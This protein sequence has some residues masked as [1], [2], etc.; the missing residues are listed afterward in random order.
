MKTYLRYLAK[1]SIL[2][3]LLLS[4]TLIKCGSTVELPAGDPDNGGLFLPDGFE[5]IVVVDSLKGRARHMAVNDNGDIYVKARFPREGGNIALRD[6]TGD[7]K[8]DIIQQFGTYKAD[9]TYGTAMRIHNGYLYYSSQLV[10]YRSKLKPGQLLPDTTHEVILTDDHAHGS[11]EHVA[12]PITFD[13]RGNMYVPFGANSNNCQEVNRTPN[14]PGMNPCPLLADHGGIWRFDAS[15]PGQLQKDGHLFAT[16]LR[17]VVALDWN[18]QDKNLYA[19]QHGRDDLLRLWSRFFSPWESA[20]LPSEEFLRVKDGTHAGWP[21]CYYDQLKGQKLLAPEYGGDGTMAGDCGKY[22]KPLIGFPGH[23][24]PNDLLFYQGNQFPERYR[25]G[26]F[27]AFHGS[28]N[29]GPYPQAGYFIAFVPFKDGQPSGPWEVFADGFAGVDPI[30]NTRDAKYRPMG[31]AMGP[32]GS[33]YFSDTEKGKIWR[34]MYKGD[35]DNFGDAQLAKMEERKSLSNIRKP[36]EINDNLDKGIAVGGEKVYSVY[37]GTCHQRDG[38]G[39]SGRFPPLAGASFVKGDKKLLISI[40]IKGMEGPIEVNG[41]QFNATM[42]QHSFLSNEDIAKVLTYI[43]ENFGNNASA[44][45]S[46]E[47]EAVRKALD[48]N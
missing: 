21:Y 9:G 30:V 25:N 13:D 44:V 8:A 3:F 27:I 6:T 11:H 1:S 36:H 47:V 42:P 24:A 38:K 41:E 37:C 2:F 35:K 48:A 18:H 7:G 45:T 29:R 20:E 40:V 19:L 28:T 4:V 43:R 16:G 12:K 34:V 32:D 31:I 46:E 14:S 23:W 17:S 5:A 22:E 26:A 39:A 15:K 10:V 33:L